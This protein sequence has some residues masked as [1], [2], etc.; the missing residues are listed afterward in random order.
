MQYIVTNSSSMDP[1][2]NAA[3]RIG[4]RWNLPKG[5]SVERESCQE[6]ANTKIYEPHRLRIIV[7]AGSCLWGVVDGT[8]GV[9]ETCSDKDRRK[10][11]K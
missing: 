6:V 3:S 2:R 8:P 7:K 10:M 4:E 1:N 9:H 5:E 11:F